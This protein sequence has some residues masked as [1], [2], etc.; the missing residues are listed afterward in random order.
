MYRDVWISR[1]EIELFILLS[2]YIGITTTRDKTQHYTGSYCF[3]PNH[4]DPFAVLFSGTAFALH[5]TR[6]L[7]KR[8]LQCLLSSLD[9]AYE[10]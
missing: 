6:V 3:I 5:K 8:D 1:I 9:Y 7:Y 10:L 4:H 2:G